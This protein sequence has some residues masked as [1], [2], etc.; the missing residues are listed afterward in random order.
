MIILLKYKFVFFVKS[1]PLILL[2]RP[3][4][5]IFGQEIQALKST[6]LMLNCNRCNLKYPYKVYARH[7]SKCLGLTGS[8]KSNNPLSSASPFS[9]KRSSSAPPYAYSLLLF[10]YMIMCGYEHIN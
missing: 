3:G 1:N 10:L 8:R 5:D 2:D 6:K 4:F 7:F 9:F